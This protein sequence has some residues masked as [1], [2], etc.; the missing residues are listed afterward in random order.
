MPA[1]FDG[2]SLANVPSMLNL[3]TEFGELDLTF[4]PSGELRGFEEW[5]AHAV[6]VE[7]ANGVSVAVVALD[8]VI[9]SKHAANRPK[10]QN[11]AAISSAR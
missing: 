3:V 8:D 10:D 9:A 4:A 2:P 1:R 7:I 6:V 11:G 5:N